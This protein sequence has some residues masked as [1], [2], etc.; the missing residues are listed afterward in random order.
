MSSEFEKP[1]SPAGRR[2]PGAINLKK[3]W[4]RPLAIVA[5]TTLAG[6]YNEDN[7]SIKPAIL[8]PENNNVLFLNSSPFF[9]SLE[10]LRQTQ[11]PTVSIADIAPNMAIELAPTEDSQLP[12]LADEPKEYVTK[13]GDFLSKI[14]KEVYGTE[15]FWPVLAHVNGI[16][17]P[18]LLYVDTKLTIPPQNEAESI[19]ESLPPITIPQLRIASATPGVDV[20]IWDLLAQCESGGNWSADTGNRFYG[21]LQFTLESWQLAGGTGNPAHAS[22]EEQIMRAQILLTIQGWGAWPQCSF[23]LGLH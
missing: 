6:V 5:V 17:S 19:M 9:L 18:N 3:N 4:W 2:A 21:G 8:E 23:V 16:E 20:S 22:R 15:K 7:I 13:P 1:A 10:D 11:E 14:S 12:Q